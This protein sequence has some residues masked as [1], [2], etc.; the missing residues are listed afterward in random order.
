VVLLPHFSYQV[1][2]DGGIYGAL[3]PPLLVLLHLYP[4]TSIGKFYEIKITDNTT[5]CSIIF[6]CVYT[7][8]E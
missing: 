4:A 5:S 3:V 2:I 7:V 8:P 1:A 6:K